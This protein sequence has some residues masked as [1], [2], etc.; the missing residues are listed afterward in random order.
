MAAKQYKK[1]EETSIKLAIDPTYAQLT[2]HKLSI[3]ELS[4]DLMK[5][6][7]VFIILNM[8]TKTQAT[9]LE[10]AKLYF[11]NSNFAEAKATLDKVFDK[12]SDQL[13]IN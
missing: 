8:Q 5:L 9:A 10:I 3:T 11:I 2:K 1:A 6:L 4:K 7:K 13:I 12:V